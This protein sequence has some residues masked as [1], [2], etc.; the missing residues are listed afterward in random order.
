MKCAIYVFIA[1]CLAIMLESCSMAPVRTPYP[2]RPYEITSPISL[3]TY[4]IMHTVT[5]GET[6]WHLSKMYNVNIDDIIK[7]NKLIEPVVLE[8]GQHIF[9]PPTIS[10]QPTIPLYATSKWQYII[11][12]HSATNEG[13]AWFINR[14]HKR[15]GWEGIGYY[16][17][18]DNGTLGKEDGAIEVSPRWLKQENGAHCRASDMNCRGIGICLVGNFSK[19]RVSKKQLDSLVYL[20]NLLKKYY[21]IPVSH[22]MGHGQVPEAKTECPGKFFPWEEFKNELQNRN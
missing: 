1:I 13:D 8:V 4:G 3:P 16:F 11:I 6:L 5:A 19:E 18:I 10:K 21:K 12:H 17:I 15:R 22:I 14:L 7:A 2:I 9:I 20:T